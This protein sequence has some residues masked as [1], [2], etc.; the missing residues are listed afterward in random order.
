LQRRTFTD[1]RRAL[2]VATIV[3]FG[4]C[5]CKRLHVFVPPCFEFSLEA[6]APK[7]GLCASN[8]SKLCMSKGEA[9]CKLKQGQIRP[10]HS[11][12]PPAYYPS[13]F[14]SWLSAE[15]PVEVCAAVGF[16][17]HAPKLLVVLLTARVDFLT[18][19]MGSTR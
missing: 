18:A 11:Y 1:P 8:R 4:G 9:V 12:F 3:Q 17:T 2:R 19:H 7:D 16:L 13:R 10:M 6:Y 15:S 5:G 14:L